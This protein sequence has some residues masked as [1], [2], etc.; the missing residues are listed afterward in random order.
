MTMTDQHIVGKTKDTGYQIGMR[1]TFPLS[2]EQAWKLITSQ[3]AIKIWLG[4]VEGYRL[5]KGEQYQTNDGTRGEVRVV[6]P[7]ENI[8]LTWQ[9]RQW[10]RVSTIQVRVIS[11]G[12]EKTVIS[13]HQENLSSDVE[14]EQMR[15]RWMKVLHAL[16]MLLKS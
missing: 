10:S 12:R 16:Q 5:V 3:E 6:N 2:L 13:F 15:S 1:K 14:R 7:R 11:T 4:D 8:R 9:P